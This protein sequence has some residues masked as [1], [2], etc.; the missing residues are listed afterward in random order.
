MSP[1]FQS[2]L[3]LVGVFTLGGVTGGSLTR[4]YGARRTQRSLNEATPPVFRQ[5]VFIEALDRNVHLDDDQLDEVRAIMREHEPEIREIRRIIGP[6]TRALR[7]AALDEIRRVMRP[8]QLPRFQRFVDRQDAHM[9]RM[10]DDST[11]DG[12]DYPSP[13]GPGFPGPGNTGFP[14]GQGNQGF[15]GRPPGR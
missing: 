12:Q 10:D 14:P 3:V 11:P 9:R 6:R 5:R 1:R 8:D 7:A 15:P 2:I 4:F 13:G